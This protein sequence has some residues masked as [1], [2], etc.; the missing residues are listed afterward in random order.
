M[1]HQQLDN[2]AVV[3]LCNGDAVA[4][5]WVQLGRRYVHELDDLRDEDLPNANVA[6]GTERICRIGAM[7]IKL[8]SHPFWLRNH[9]ALASHMMINTIQ[10]AD[11]CRWES[12]REDWKREFSDWNRHGWLNVCLAVGVICHGGE[13]EPAR[14]ESAEMWTIAY[15][16]HHDVN[17]NPV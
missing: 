9:Q 2:D 3:R 1:Q 7:A 8:F 14:A 11:S 17:G 15:R 10:Y 13:Y 5:D 6:G 4:L 16:D 12:A